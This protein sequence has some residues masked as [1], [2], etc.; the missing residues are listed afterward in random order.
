VRKQSEGTGVLVDTP[1]AASRTSSPATGRL[2]G[3]DAEGSPLIE[4]AAR[5]LIG[6]TCVP[7][8]KHD[9]GREVVF[10]TEADGPG[11]PIVI[12]VIKTPADTLAVEM[13]ADGRSASIHA[14]DS[15]TLTCGEASI[16]LKRNGEV[17]IRGKHVVTHAAGVNRIRGGSVQLN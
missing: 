8:Q 14:A 15:I 9:F 16:T 5:T 3:F 7:L 11:H 2:I 4:C 6:R 17:L 13:S 10:V 12:G 1:S